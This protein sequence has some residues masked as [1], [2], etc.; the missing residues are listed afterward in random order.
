VTGRALME[1]GELWR[2]ERPL[3]VGSGSIVAIAARGRRRRKPRKRLIGRTLRVPGGGL[4]RSRHP[5][6][7]HDDAPGSRITVCEP[8]ERPGLDQEHAR[9]QRIADLD[10][11]T[12]PLWSDDLATWS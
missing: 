1:A 4:V 10:G 11:Y 7:S 5:P 8:V 6:P 12:N 2:L 3:A 9:V